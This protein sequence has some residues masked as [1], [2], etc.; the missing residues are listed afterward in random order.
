VKSYIFGQLTD[1][2]I[3]CI[4]HHFDEFVDFNSSF[5][6]DIE[7]NKFYVN[8]EE[9]ELGSVFMRHNVFEKQTQK[10]YANHYMLYNYILANPHIK[11]HNRNKM[12]PPIAKLYD[13]KVAKEIGFNIPHTVFSQ[14]IDRKDQILKPVTGGAHVVKGNKAAY[15]CII[16]DRIIGKNIR[17]YVVKDKIFSF[18]IITSMLDYREDTD[19]D[20]KC[21]E[22]PEDIKDKIIELSKRLDLSF[23]AS[24]F[25]FDGVNYYYLETNDMPMFVVF[26][27][28]TKGQ[29]GK[30]MYQELC[31]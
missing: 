26:D 30:S 5:E 22:V 28:K 6:W 20:C 1:P 23:S 15:P 18:E 25:M 9:L 17:I 13:L 16:Q 4:K 10:K 12:M 7:Q 27:N 3:V 24:D 8:K 2:N 11:V 31:K 19:V 21:V 29:L 14:Q